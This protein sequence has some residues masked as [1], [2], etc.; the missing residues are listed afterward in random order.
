M[1][2]P[3]P[4]ENPHPESG[5]SVPDRPTPTVA[6]LTAAVQQAAE[7]V[8]RVTGGGDADADRSAGASLQTTAPLQTE[9]LRKTLRPDDN[10]S[11]PDAGGRALDSSVAG[12]LRVVD[13]ESDAA[14]IPTKKKSVLAPRWS[15]VITRGIVVVLVWAF[16]SFVFDPLIQSVAVQSAQT[17]VSAKVDVQH[18]STEF[19]PPRVRIENVA[20]ASRKK[21]GTNLIEFATL[22]GDVDGLALMKKSFIFNRAAVTGLQWGTARK[23]TG[24]LEEAED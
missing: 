14:T 3:N 12:D 20:V 1:A 15:Y 9:A 16:F 19:F 24:T 23:D 7:T 21:P 2:S 18:L 11:S 5:R 10:G 6:E 17:I 13:T 4:T 22:E 8:A